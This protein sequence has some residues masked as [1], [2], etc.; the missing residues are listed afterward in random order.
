MCASASATRSASIQCWTTATN[1][2]NRPPR[3]RT[4][5]RPH[6]PA[7]RMVA[8]Q[9]YVLARREGRKPMSDTTEYIKITHRDVPY[10]TFDA[11]NHM[12][13]NRD[14]FTQFLPPEYQGLVKYVE[15][16]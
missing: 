3:P 4:L 6:R 13:E 11:D 16:N 5:G 14:A 10:S 8:G 9:S 15:I 2:S 1:T 7:M 12:Y